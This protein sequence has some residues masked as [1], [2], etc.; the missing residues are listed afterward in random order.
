[1]DISFHYPPELMNLLIDT[2]PR[3]CRS[4]KDVLLFLKGAGVSDALTAD[5]WKTVQ[6]K[7]GEVNK[8]EIVR[9]VLTRLNERHEATLRERR[10]ILKR[11]I[12]FDDFSTCWE[13]DRLE[14]QGLVAQIQKVVN[15]KDSFMRMKEEREREHR[16]HVSKREAE[17]ARLREH[18]QTIEQLRTE[19]F[20]LFGETHPHKRGKKLENLLN[21]LF[22][23]IG[24]SIREAFTV[25]GEN[26][27]GVVEQIDGVIELDGHL[28][29][30][31]VKWWQDPAGVPEIS[32][33]MMRVFLRAES[34]AIIISA[35][36]FTAPAIAE[37]KAALVQK[38]VTLCTL[39]EI[40][41]VLEKQ[42]DLGKF[43]R[44]KVHLTIA[45]RSPFATVSLDELED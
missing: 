6:F 32:Q 19:L 5:L 29:F 35:A 39:H 33:H 38:V 30:V 13:S 2:I 24:I 4:K 37:C 12:E 45:D 18:R 7:P 8:F 9:K 17:L 11:V 43:F 3:L 16:E 42:L 26:G 14:A 15:T 40:V 10:E 44:R 25:S 41:M 31:E 23:A 27:E 34:R 22:Q 1:M 21:R 28:Y 36:G 20:A